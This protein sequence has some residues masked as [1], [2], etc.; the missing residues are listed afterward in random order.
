LSSVPRVELKASYNIIEIGGEMKELRNSILCIVL[1]IATLSL[2]ILMVRPAYAQSTEPSPPKFSMQ[3]PNAST[4][5]LVVEN[6][7][8]TNS[9]SVNSLVYYF[10]VKAHNSDTWMIDGDYTLQSNSDTTI[11]SISPET[12]GAEILSTPFFDNSTSFDFQVQAVTG[13]YSV[14]WKPGY[15]PGMP[16]QYQ[17]GNGYWDITF[18]PAESSDW[19]PTQTVA[20][21][22]SSNSPSSTLVPTQI[23]FSASNPAANSTNDPTGRFT[24]DENTTKTSSAA[25]I[26]EFLWLVILPLFLSIFFI[27]VTLRHR[28]IINV[29][30]ET[31][32]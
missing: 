24:Q 14:T 13:F 4:I 5:Q 2:S 8:F 23:P 17:S 3:T 6:Q 20:M 22:V 25:A 10:R 16:T 26:P 30:K 12:G 31:S 1:V 18:N 11:I 29:K 15:M 28:K 19:S 27:A 7:A 32:C 21:P 9:S